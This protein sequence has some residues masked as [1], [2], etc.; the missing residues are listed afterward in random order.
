MDDRRD[1]GQLWGSSFRVLPTKLTCNP[2][3]K[4]LYMPWVG[5]LMGSPRYSIKGTA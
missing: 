4:A 3:P 2:V 5:P 1:M